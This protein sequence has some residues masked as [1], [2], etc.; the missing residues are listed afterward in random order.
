MLPLGNDVLS[1]NGSANPR[2]PIDSA[3][4]GLSYALMLVALVHEGL[5]DYDRPNR[6]SIGES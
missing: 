6:L 2:P 1:T 3:R 5:H 4:T